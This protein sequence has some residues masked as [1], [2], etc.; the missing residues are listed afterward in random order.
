MSSSAQTVPKSTVLFTEDSSPW[1]ENWPMTYGTIQNNSLCYWFYWT[2]WNNMNV[3]K[4]N[5][6]GKPVPG[7]F[8]TCGMLRV[9]ACVSAQWPRTSGVCMW[10]SLRIPSGISWNKGLI[11]KSEMMSSCALVARRPV[12]FFTN[13]CMVFSKALSATVLI[14]WRFPFHLTLLLIDNKLF[15][16]FKMIRLD[17][18]TYLL[19]CTHFGT[20]SLSTFN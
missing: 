15:A 2:S 9:L 19:V 7:T 4:I 16:A 20:F 12:W 3:N 11:V 6:S 17:L 10:C 8:L 5:A 13:V 14:I 1:S 18:V